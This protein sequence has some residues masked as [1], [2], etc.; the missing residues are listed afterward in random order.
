[1]TEVEPGDPAGRAGHSP[2]NSCEERIAAACRAAGRDRAELTLVAVTK[3][4]PATT[5]GTCTPSGVR[6]VGENRDQDAAAKA[7]ACRAAGLTD[8]VWHFV[9]QVQT[10]KAAVGGRLRRR[11]A[12]GRP[13]AGWC[14]R[15]TGQRPRPA[16]GL[17]VLV[18]V[19]LSRCRAAGAGRRPADV[20]A[21]AEAIAAADALDL[22]GA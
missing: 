3:T 21:L 16:A 8:L 17:G 6:D 1:M 9:G 10:N 14:R 12:L 4:F 2:R 15:W 11:R 22:L 5:C 7:D 19:D 20:P 18:Q 13:A